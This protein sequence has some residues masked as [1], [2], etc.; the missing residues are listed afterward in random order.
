MLL[1]RFKAVRKGYHP[2]VKLEQGADGGENGV[3]CRDSPPASGDI[4]ETQVFHPD[5]Q[6]HTSQ[7]AA[8]CSRCLPGAPPY[9]RELVVCQ[10]DCTVSQLT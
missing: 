1:I 2:E 3:L 9:T 4:Q 6:R 8:E 10:G 5:S 7:P